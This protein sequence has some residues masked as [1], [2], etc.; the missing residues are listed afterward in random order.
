MEVVSLRPMPRWFTGP[1]WAN[2]FFLAQPGEAAAAGLDRETASVEWF[3]W[4]EAEVAIRKTQVPHRR[5]RDLEILAAAQGVLRGLAPADP[6]PHWA[7]APVEVRQLVSSVGGYLETDMEEFWSGLLAAWRAN[8]D[9]EGFKAH[10][11]ALRE[12]LVLG[13]SLLLQAFFLA[14]AA[15][16]NDLPGPRTKGNPEQPVPPEKI[17]PRLDRGF[18]RSGVKGVVLVEDGKAQLLPASHPWDASEWCRLA[19]RF[20]PGWVLSADKTALA[21]WCVGFARAL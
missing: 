3:T 4:E 18:A 7:P 15:L 1:Q 10:A 6:E 21:A 17:V 19:A 2:F 11:A 13:D 8:W 20:V 9:P 12:P 16:V 5:D 14:T